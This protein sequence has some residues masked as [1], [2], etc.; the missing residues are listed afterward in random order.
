MVEQG[1]SRAATVPLED[2]ELAAEDPIDAMRNIDLH[3]T[4]FGQRLDRMLDDRCFLQ[5]ILFWP[6]AQKSL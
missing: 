5:P 3:F 4:A 2:A 6:P 1:N